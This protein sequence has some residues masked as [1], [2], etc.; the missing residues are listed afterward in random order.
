MRAMSRG[1]IA[2]CID[3]AER[4]LNYYKLCNR[5]AVP[6]GPQEAAQ[7][8]REYNREYKPFRVL[9]GYSIRGYVNTIAENIGLII[10]AYPQ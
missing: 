10:D 4:V 6:G 3:Y 8:V 2:D 1:E 9:Y 5:G 7:A